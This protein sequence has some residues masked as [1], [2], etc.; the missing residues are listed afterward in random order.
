LTLHAEPSGQAAVPAAADPEATPLGW[1]IVEIRPDGTWGLPHVVANG[2]AETA[3]TRLDPTAYAG[4]TSR[5]RELMLVLQAHLAAQH[6]S[7]G[8][9]QLAATALAHGRTGRPVSAAHEDRLSRLA[10]AE[11]MHGDLR[12]ASRHAAQARSRTTGARDSTIEHAAL[13]SAWVALERAE[14]A[15]ARRHLDRV[16]AASSQPGAEP[17]LGTSRLLVEA[18]LLI[19]GGEP[20]SATRLLAGTRDLSWP[21]RQ[22]DWLSD[23][24]TVTKAQALLAE[25]E[26]QRA[27]AVVT[28]LPKRAFVEGS[29]VMSAARYDIGD[30]RG[31]LAVLNRAVA[32]L[33]RA[34]LAVQIEAWLLEA[35][36]SHDT[37]K[38]DRTRLLVD[39]VLRSATT[40]Q[41]RRPLLRDWRWLR[42]FLDR[43]AALQRAHR[44][45]LSTCQLDHVAAPLRSVSGGGSE[46]PIGAPLTERESQVLDLLAQMY[47]TEEIAAALYVSSNT[48]KTHLKGIFGKL[49]VN[50]RV[51]A[52]RRGRQL[53]LC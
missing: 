51:E 40:E 34:P 10:H 16:S 43:D 45:F 15:Q 29:V 21:A 35:R 44:E 24:V 47:S 9:L 38:Q 20:E 22:K 18:G 39:R 19:A 30:T 52:V 27:I 33:E 17:W 11:A 53:G 1:A 41:M 49:C 31:A 26:P 42:A 32:E 7:D 46:Q 6:V 50:R 48:V 13:A 5:H 36:I 25:G 4:G 8:Q 28:P 14:F 37:G 3:T 12:R 23:L 2:S